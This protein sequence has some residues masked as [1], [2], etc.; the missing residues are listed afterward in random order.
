M[1]TEKLKYIL[2]KF[3]RAFLY[4]PGVSDGNSLKKQNVVLKITLVFLEHGEK[5]WH[6]L[7]FSLACFSSKIYF[8]NILFI[9]WLAI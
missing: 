1:E 8:W 3:P 4:A 7:V 5:Y 9:S 2:L 6:P